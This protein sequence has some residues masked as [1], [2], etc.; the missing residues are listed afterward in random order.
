[1]RHKNLEMNYEDIKQALGD[2]INECTQENFCKGYDPISSVIDNLEIK[3]LND[4][5]LNV[6][7]YNK[8]EI[9]TDESYAIMDL[10]YNLKPGDPY[11]ETEFALDFYGNI[12]HYSKLYEDLF[13]GFEE[14]L[15]EQRSGYL[16]FDY[17]Y[18]L[19]YFIMLLYPIEE[20]IQ[21]QAC[22]DLVEDDWG[23]FEDED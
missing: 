14:D 22:L 5:E 2:L 21:V 10:L 12:F 17:H 6:G 23:I 19:D 16:D 1:M 4:L 20:D 3:V 13:N 8:V 7:R 11:Y 15:V 9:G 18:L